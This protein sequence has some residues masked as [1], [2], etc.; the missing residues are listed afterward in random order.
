MSAAYSLFRSQ[1]SRDRFMT[2]TNAPPPTPTAATENDHDD[3]NE[4]SFIGTK[5]P[6]I[7]TS[8]LRQ[9]DMGILKTLA[10]YHD[11][12]HPL[13]TDGC[14]FSSSTS[15][16]K[17]MHKVDIDE[18]MM[19]CGWALE[20]F[21]RTKE[22]LL[23]KPFSLENMDK[24][25]SF[26]GLINDVHKTASQD[27]TSLEYDF[28]KMTTPTIFLPLQGEGIIRLL[29]MLQS[30]RRRGWEEDEDD[31]G[32]GGIGKTNP[33]AAAS[34]ATTTTT[35]LPK[36]ENIRVMNVALLSARVREIY[37]PS[38]PSSPLSDD[39]G[40]IT[41]NKE[42]QVITQ[43][44]ILYELQQKEGDEH[45]GNNEETTTTTT[46]TRINTSVMVG[47]FEACLEGDPNH[48]N[49]TD[50]GEDDNATTTTNHEWKLASYR[51]ASEY[52]N[53]YL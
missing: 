27:P 34:A 28:I 51:L 46:T 2:L 43:L 50:G 18:F 36:F 16:S 12:C 10:L 22:E 15:G 49:R 44:E 4:A 20:Q 30:S 39:H 26:Y 3:D 8:V 31:D 35:T 24:S 13:F 11:L 7:N 47:T 17:R 33:T 1:E 19:G 40:T 5:G 29:K 32:I 38:P 53:I 37:P 42:A 48:H 52:D 25:T 6:I 41:K 21:H 14:R 45:G 23:I 9:S